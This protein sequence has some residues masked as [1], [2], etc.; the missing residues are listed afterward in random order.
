[1]TIT[2]DG[3][4]IDREVATLR[5]EASGMQARHP[6]KARSLGPSTLADIEQPAGASTTYY[7]QPVLKA[8]VWKAFIPAYFWVGGIAGGCM[9]IGAAAQLAG[10]KRL[11]SV[12]APARMIATGSVIVSAALLIAD[13]GR[14]ARFLNMLRVFRP[15]SPMN[16]GTWILS[17]A[18]AAVTASTALPM[19][20]MKRAGDAAGLAAGVLGLGLAS[21]T[22]V[23]VSSTAVPAW[24]HGGKQL[25]PLFCASA[26]ASAAAAL[27]LVPSTAR[28]SAA[29][30]IFGLAGK[31]GE[32][33]A[34]H[35]YERALEAKGGAVVR[36]V[37]TGRAGQLMR[38]SRALT[39]A[40]IVASLFEY[41]RASGVLALGGALA[42]RFGVVAAGRS[43]ALDPRATFEP[44]R[45][46]RAARDRM[47]VPATLTEGTPAFGT[48]DASVA[49][50]AASV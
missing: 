47:R 1:M 34:G 26:A 16:M 24:Q 25:P 50:V 22:A 15:T 13:L 43:S 31:A 4:N 32:L 37:R 2:E 45:D 18:G 49:P 7:E 8:P 19:V 20:G 9:A 33:V 11:R 29:L 38:A 39:A 40:S 30:R 41:R 46:R 14:P 42:L 36:H 10:D 35:M 6:S 28:A 17:G 27:D 48:V 21:Y 12:V 23:L 44:Q 3:R 5:G